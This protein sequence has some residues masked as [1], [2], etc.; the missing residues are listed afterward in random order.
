MA[1]REVTSKK[2]PLFLGSIQRCSQAMDLRILRAMK[3]SEEPRASVKQLWGVRLMPPA[4]FHICGDRLDN[5]V[6]IEDGIQ[7]DEQ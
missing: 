7:D 3:Q 4:A 1:S 5:K 6:E 2:S